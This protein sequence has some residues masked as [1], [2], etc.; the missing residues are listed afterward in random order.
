V[1]QHG[2]SH[3]F[4]R[5]MEATRDCDVFCGRFCIATWMVMANHNRNRT[6]AYRISKDLTWVD[7]RRCMISNRYKINATDMISV[8]EMQGKEVLSGFPNRPCADECGRL[9]RSAHRIDRPVIGERKTFC[10]LRS[11]SDTQ[12]AQWAQMGDGVK[13]AQRRSAKQRKPWIPLQ[14][15]GDCLVSAMSIANQGSQEGMI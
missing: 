13:L 3:D 15:P 5:F 9:F 4:A 12:C 1:I 10:K 2:D 7:K 14:Q 8:I 6:A 11:G